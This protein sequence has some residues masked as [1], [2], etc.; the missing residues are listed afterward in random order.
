MTTI[1][2]TIESDGV[3]VL[4]NDDRGTFFAD[5]LAKDEALGEIAS[6]L[7]VDKPHYGVSPQSLMRGNRM[8]IEQA[9]AVKKK[10]VP[11]DGFF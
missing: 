3:S 4:A 9:E 5:R 6:W 2:I 10:E 1:P 11:F 8:R 7:Y